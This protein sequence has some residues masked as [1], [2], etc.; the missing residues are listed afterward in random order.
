MERP[1]PWAELKTFMLPTDEDA[2]KQAL[3]D[4]GLWQ[5]ELGIMA[6]LQDDD[7]G[8][9]DIYWMANAC[10]LNAQA[11]IEKIRKEMESWR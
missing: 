8:R 10:R 6:K 3:E 9:G 4:L 2:R 7:R 11:E 5:R 1:D